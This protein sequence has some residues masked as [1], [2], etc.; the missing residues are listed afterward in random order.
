MLTA[1]LTDVHAN[2]QALEACLAHAAQRQAGRYAF[3]G[4]LVGYG[5][6][7]GW[8]VDTVMHYAARGALVVMGNHDYAAAVEERKQMHAEAREAID[9]TRNHL[10]PEQ[11]DFL[12]KLPLQIRDSGVLYV[13]ASA[14]EPQEWIYVNTLED[15]VR[16]MQATEC[17]LIFSGHVHMPALYRIAQDGKSGGHIPAPESV[18]PIRAQHQYLAIPGSCGQPRDGNTSASYALYDDQS[19]M[20]QFFRVPYDISG[21]ARRVIEVGLPMVF[22]M[23]LVEGL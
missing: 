10:N 23:R 17:R 1:I 5:G 6:D 11:L 8:V 4:D 20:L 19:G 16:S 15:A 21:A 3:L 14:Y 7:P 22:A 12:R 13:H 18:H 9:W 2:R